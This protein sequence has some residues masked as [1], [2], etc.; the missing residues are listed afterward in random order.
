[1]VNSTPWT[2]NAIREASG[3]NAKDRL[4]PSVTDMETAPLSSALISPSRVASPDDTGVSGG[5]SPQPDANTMTN[6]VAATN[7][8]RGQL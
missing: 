2:L 1:M 4:V 8:F 6:V 3:L 7:P 5:A